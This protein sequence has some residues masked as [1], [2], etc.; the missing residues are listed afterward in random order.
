MNR[1]LLASLALCLPLAAGCASDESLKP[2]AP[3]PVPT[4]GAMFQT[5]VSLGNSITAGFQ[6]AGINDSTQKRSYAV[7]LAAAMGTQFQYPSLLGRGC[8]P[9][10]ANNVTQA[11]V[12]GG[13]STTCDLRGT[14]SSPI[15]NLAVPGARAEE[16]LSNFGVPVSASN[17]L[18]LLFLGGATQ[19]QRMGELKPTFVSAWIGNNDVLGSLTSLTN[20]GNPLLVTSQAV[21]QAQFDSITDSI[22]A[23]GAK[24]LLIAVGDVASIPYAS[25]GA[26][27]WCIKN[28]PACGPVPA[29]FPPTF[30]V[31]NNCAPFAAIPGAKGDSTLAPW[32]IWI[33]KLQAALGGQAQ[34]L[35]CSV[36]SLVVT[37]A[38][39][40]NL[41]TAVET[42]NTHVKSVA[43]AHGWAYWDPDSTLHAEL[44]SAT[45]PTGRIPAFPDLSQA[46]TGGSVRFGPLFSLDGVHP[47]AL[48]HRLLADSAAS[49]INAKYGTTLP[50][51][52]CGTVTCP[53]P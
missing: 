14:F 40:K 53:A 24:A 3:P 52:V 21:F 6:S 18:T 8:P 35:D 11:R 22:A 31:N 44:Q 41:R 37:A 20:P 7:L 23:V 25:T 29:A 50:V 27:Y 45:N 47:S 46:L 17:A 2:P 33:P 30:T 5:Y 16:V 43:N 34:N 4:G 19:L 10:F 39:F 42:F 51:P 32:P 26:A 12:G 49:R 15:T 48:G 38:E 36:D 13:T 1:R 28:Q 9:P